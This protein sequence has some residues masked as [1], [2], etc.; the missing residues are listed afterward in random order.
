MTIAKGYDRLEIELRQYISN[1][2]PVAWIVPISNVA[3]AHWIMPAEA[4][5][6][7][8]AHREGK[9]EGALDSLGSNFEPWFIKEAIKDYFNKEKYSEFAEELKK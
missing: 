7:M 5:K 3:Y 1:Y 4:E 2:T 6:L 8:K 9:L